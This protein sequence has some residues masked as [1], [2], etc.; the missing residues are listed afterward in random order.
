MTDKE[1]SLALQISAGQLNKF[2]RKIILRSRNAANTH[3]ALTVMEAFVSSF[4]SDSHATDD[5]KNTQEIIK[6]YSA[7]TREKLMQE[8]SQQLT[9]GLL[10]HNCELLAQVYC[11][12]SRNGFSRI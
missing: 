4:S 5:Y 7:E 12:L 9:E 1:T 10:A 6:S 2:C 3:E 8:R 11:S